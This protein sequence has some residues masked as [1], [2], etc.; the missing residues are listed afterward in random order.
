MNKLR[1]GKWEDIY[2]HPARL[3]QSV[4]EWPMYVLGL[5]GSGK[6]TL[7]ANLALRLNAMGEGMLVIDHKDGQ[8]ARDIAARADPNHLIYISP[9]ECVFDGKMHHWGL[10]PLEVAQRDSFGFATAYA[11]TMQMFDRMERAEFGTMQ[12]M[13]QSLDGA[14]KLALYNRHP[15]LLDVRRIL[16]EK[17]YR[18]E[19]LD[20][21]NVPDELREQWVRFDDNK[22]TTISA[23]Q[24]QISSSMP[25]LK[26]FLNDRQLFY[27]V[28]QPTS[29]VRLQEWLDAGKLIVCNFSTNLDPLQ[30]ELLAN[31]LLAV[32]MNHAMTREESARQ[33][34]WRLIA[35]EFDE[36]ALGN[37]AT[38]INKARNRRVIPIMAHQNLSQLIRDGNQTVL[39]AVTEAPIKLTFRTSHADQKEASWVSRS[40]LKDSL[41]TLDRY[42]AVLTVEDGLPGLLDTGESGLVLLGP[43]EGEAMALRNA[44]ASQ[45]APVTAERELRRREKMEGYDDHQDPHVRT[46]DLY[47]ENGQPVPARDDSASYS[48]HGDAEPVRGPDELAGVQ[49][50][51]PEPTQ[52]RRGRQKRR[53]RTTR[54]QPGVPQAPQ[55]PGTG[56]GE[57][58]RHP[59]QPASQ[60]GDQ[61]PDQDGVR[62]ADSPPPTPRPGGPTLPPPEPDHP[63]DD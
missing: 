53:R 45:R 13:W 43:L 63:P 32:F 23:R 25:R 39:K 28:T 37:F 29:T 57:T 3:P 44:I 54:H 5:P 50:P 46:E 40:D 38:L 9:C 56:E 21:P 36:L 59:Q 24:Q 52:H 30:G 19:C 4:Y 14:I 22:I 51:V 42:T 26:A 47:Q 27:M 10:N 20:N 31:L 7:L 11:N 58:D 18:Q 41:S 16:T 60:V 8:L 55:R 35:D 2:Y 61:L 17:A 12:Q 1:V 15:T 33:R 34:V 6:S 62:G 48:S 49:A